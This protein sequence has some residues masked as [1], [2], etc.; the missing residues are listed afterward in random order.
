MVCL[1]GRVSPV[2]ESPGLREFAQQVHDRRSV[3]RVHRLRPL[4]CAA[5]IALSAMLAVPCALRAD[6]SPG[7]NV[8][9]AATVDSNV[10]RSRGADKLSDTV[11]GVK[12]SKSLTVPISSNTRLT[13]LGAVGAERFDRYTG[14]SR[15]FLDVNGEYQYRPSGAF[16][17]PTFGVFFN[18]TV[19]QYQSTLRDGPVD[20]AAP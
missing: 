19:E 4:D 13:V 1:T 20:G 8:E 6:D 3:T 15:V 18:S 14:L 5:I 9:A 2:P 16:D 7:L 17:A 11:L 10:T 12:V